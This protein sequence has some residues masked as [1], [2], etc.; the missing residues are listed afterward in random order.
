[1]ALVLALLGSCTCSHG[2]PVAYH[3]R[4]FSRPQPSFLG[5]EIVVAAAFAFGAFVVLRVAAQAASALLPTGAGVDIWKTIA[6]LD[7]KLLSTLVA[8]LFSAIGW[9]AKQ[10]VGR[11]RFRL[12]ILTACD[13]LEDALWRGVNDG[14]DKALTNA[15]TIVRVRDT[16]VDA[17]TSELRKSLNSQI[18]VLARGLGLLPPVSTGKDD[19][20]RP[21][22]PS[23]IEAKTPKKPFQSICARR[24]V[25]V[26][27]CRHRRALP[28]TADGNHCTHRRA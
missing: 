21:A 19:E 12:F 5:P 9:F 1:M 10:F 22:A 16:L 13:R 4:S 2:G 14:P 8:A 17:L 15:T 23:P 6:G 26:W 11:R 24:A 3:S 20:A 18:D 25:A 27:A 7:P 28:V